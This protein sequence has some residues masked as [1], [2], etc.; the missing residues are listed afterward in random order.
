MMVSVRHFLAP[1]GGVLEVFENRGLVTPVRGFVFFVFGKSSR[2]SAAAAPVARARRAAASRPRRT[3]ADGASRRFFLSPAL[4]WMR[5]GFDPRVPPPGHPPTPPTPP[6]G[7]GWRTALCAPPARGRGGPQPRGLRRAPVAGSTQGRARWRARRGS[8]PRAASC[9]RTATDPG[10]RPPRVA[11]RFPRKTRPA[12]PAHPTGRVRPRARS[13]KPPRS[14]RRRHPCAPPVAAEELRA[15]RPVA[16]R[17]VAG[18]RV[19]GRFS[20]LQW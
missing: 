10:G 17:A 4:G 1:L 5:F 11:R 8:T 14:P 16:R 7:R 18:S 19:V 15:T 13:R 20:V 6:P 12:P 9:P 3:G 2:R